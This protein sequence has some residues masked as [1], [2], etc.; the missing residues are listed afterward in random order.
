MADHGILAYI[1]RMSSESSCD[2]ASLSCVPC[3][4]GIP[5]LTEEEWAPLLAQLAG[6]QVIEGHHLSKE[7][8]FPDFVTA[9]GFVNRIGAEAERNGHHPDIGLSWGKVRVDIHTHKIDGLTQSDF[10]L[11]AKCDGVR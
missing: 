9:L 8:A 11:A 5:A 10:I 7:Y 1:V 4:G 3:R 6:W 2:L